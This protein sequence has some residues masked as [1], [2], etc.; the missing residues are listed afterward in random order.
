M[1]ELKTLYLKINAHYEDIPF[2][3]MYVLH[4]HTDQKTSLSEQLQNHHI[5]L[6]FK[7]TFEL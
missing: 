4:T 6:T 2:S 3:H 5:V 7:V 1:L